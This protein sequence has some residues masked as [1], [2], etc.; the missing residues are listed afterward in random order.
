MNDWHEAEEHVERAH[1]LYEAGRWDEAESE[2]RTALRLN[3][4]QAEWHFNLGLTLEAAGR[5]ADAAGAFRDAHELRPD[6][7]PTALAIGVN[8]LRSERAREALVWLEKASA[9]DPSSVEAFVHRVEA[10]ARLG[11]HEQAETVFY[12]GQQIDAE[13][14]DLYVAMA[15]SLMDRRL[16]DKAVWCLREAARVDPELPGVEARLA[17]AYA[18][19]GRQERARQLYLRELRRDPGDIGTLLDLGE[20]LVEM[21]RHDEAGE[22]FRRVLEIEPDNAD[23]H[24]QLADLAE[25]VGRYDDALTHFDVVLRLDP[26]YPQA[27]RRLA[28][29]LVDRVRAQDLTQA[30][31]L[32]R[33][34]LRE[35]GDNPTKFTIEDME[36]LGQLLLDAELPSDAA[37]VFRRVLGERPNDAR[38]HHCLSVALCHMGDLDGGME[39]ARR[40]VQL[41][42]S[43]VAAMH[44][45]ALAN[46]RQG[47]PARAKYWVD[48][49]LTVDR[50][51][52]MLR[53]LRVRLRLGALLSIGAW[54]LGR[55]RKR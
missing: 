12:L 19:T 37:G 46:L 45:L 23:A 17:E 20:L 48:R 3:P 44:N 16:Y 31:R 7:A 50:E 33:A 49:G 21:H 15:D 34:D 52:V 32:L 18:E 11:E 54:V 8:E 30:R 5:H 26:E 28:G 47:R 41:D 14:A 36:E 13:H 9:M 53:R 29:L 39:A 40:A 35:L 2:L 38:A 24:F 6:D 22:K 4:Y 51:D 43:L 27:R 42:P 25:R 10:H 55:F 1:E